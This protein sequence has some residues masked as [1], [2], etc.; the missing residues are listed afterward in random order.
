MLG[1]LLACCAPV[2]SENPILPRAEGSQLAADAAAAPRILVYTH[3]AGFEHDVARRPA[4]DQLCLVEQSILDRGAAT[5]LYEAVPSRDPASFDAASLATFQGVFFYTTGELPLSKERRDAL[6]AFVEGGGAFIGS[7]CATDTLYSD[8]RYGRMIGG[9]FDNH[10]WHENVP[11]LVEDARH[12]ST[13]HLGASFEIVD[14]IYQFKAPYERARNHG[15]LKLDADKVDLARAGVHR[16]DKDFAVAWTRTHGAGRVFYTSLGHR[17]EVWRDERFLAHLDGGIA[18]ATRTEARF[19]ESS[20]ARRDAARSVPAPQVAPRPAPGFAVDL[21][22]AAPELLWPTAALALDD[23]SLLVGEVPMDMPGPTDQPIDRVVRIAPHPSGGWSRTVWAEG[24]YAVFGLETLGDTVFVMNMPNLTALRD[25]DGDGR[26]DVRQ[27]I[28]TTL[29]PPAPG[30]PGGFNDHIVSGL[31]MGMDG[32]LY[33]AVGDK[34]IPECVG[35]DG[36]R[37]TLRGGGVVRVRPDGSELQLVASGLR[38][39]L[40]VAIDARGEMYTYDNTDDGLGWWTRVTHVMSGAAYGYPHDYKSRPELVRPCIL[41]QGGGSPCGNLVYRED[42]WPAPWKGGAYFAE[43]G[44]GVVRRFDFEQRGATHGVKGHE[45]LLVAGEARAFR[46]LDV[47]E[48]PDGRWLWV[49]DWNYDGWTANVQAGRL[50]RVRRADDDGRASSAMKPLPT[51]DAGLLAVLEEPSF[52]RRLRAQQALADGGDMRTVLALVDFLVGPA[53]DRAKAH[54]WCALEELSRYGSVA[55]DDQRTRR[56][57]L[58]RTT[59]Q[60]LP[61]DLPETHAWIA[62]ALARRDD[63]SLATAGVL[64]ASAHPIVRREA[65]IALANP[66]FAARAAERDEHLVEALARE[67]DEWVRHALQRAIWLGEAAPDFALVDAG[68]R[69]LV[70]DGLRD[71]VDAPAIA[72]LASLAASGAD[73][74][75]RAHA[76][77]ALRENAF[78]EAPWDGKWWSIDPAR[79][80]PPARVVLHAST[81]A[82]L[83][84][85]RAALGDESAPVQ[86]AALEAVAKLEDREAAQ[87]V[88]ELAQRSQDARVRVEALRTLGAVRDLQAAPLLA[89]AARASD[90]SV[91]EAA[92]AS[93]VALSAHTDAALGVLSELLLDDGVAVELQVEAARALAKGGSAASRDALAERARRGLVEARIASIE[94][95]GRV[96]REASA[97]DLRALLADPEWR[98]VRAAVRELGALR[99]V[100]DHPALL[101]LLGDARLRPAVVEALARRPDAAALDAYLAGL[102]EVDATAREA[103]R[104]ALES[105]AAVVRPALEERHRAGRLDPR[106]LEIVRSIYAQV[107]PLRDWTIVGPFPR[108]GAPDPAGRAPSELVADGVRVVEHRSEAEHG[109]VDL[110]KALVARQD[111]AA[112]CRAELWSTRARRARVVLGS[113]DDVRAWLN[114]REVH[115]N[116]VDRGWSHDA[117]QFEVELAAGRNELWLRVGQNGGQWSFS[118]QVEGEGSGILYDDLR[119]LDEGL[120]RYERAVAEL[121]GDPRRGR[122]VFR[123]ESGPMCLRC[124]VVDGEGGR[125]GPELSDVALKYDRAELVRS[126]LAPSARVAEGYTSSSFELADGTLVF[127]MVASEDG[128]SLSIHDQNGESRRIAKAEVVERVAGKTSLM[129]DGLALLLTEA[130]F[131]DLVAYLGTLKMPTH[132]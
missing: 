95:L 28:L 65:A 59:D 92:L 74:T 76:V 93:A 6:F 78:G 81:A 71:R 27:E 72:R 84:A 100:E 55:D 120:A 3:S 132:R 60:L 73:A 4:P 108:R 24:L 58:W 131:A 41:D 77:L 39:I 129:P 36:R 5:G 99:Q 14:E 105:L 8:E 49:T 102:V 116:P 69:R 96:A 57:Q 90:A 23:G 54:A 79:R 70:V 118:V 7:H 12:P 97:G 111:L 83:G 124:H 38:N 52:R 123:R 40:D 101:A 117:D 98:V 127:G 26:A 80:P 32:Y 82:A 21:V 10:P 130:E 122:E 13:R 9:H 114:G 125:V 104:R 106:A 113:D 37:L 29:G 62:R 85:I 1:L 18:W 17:P 128:D 66:A 11:I 2:A 64:L 86:L 35:R 15:L 45:D 50:W 16:E 75:L 103:A 19:E 43:W 53:G 31:K 112:L 47:A 30:W 119:P 56:L 94:A 25:T 89:A 126:L 22:Q 20:S 68:S 44:K 61:L 34:G 51:T 115:D 121:V 42:A 67:G 87:A 88:R 48:S 109:F 63:A 91:R 110:E 46:P 107:A 33:V